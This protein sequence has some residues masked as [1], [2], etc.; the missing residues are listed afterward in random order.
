MFW[1]TLAPNESQLVGVEQLACPP[2]PMGMDICFKAHTSTH[3]LQNRESEQTVAVGK[4]MRATI[5]M[6]QRMKE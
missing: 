2:F 3:H 5:Y 4:V 6:Y 1:K